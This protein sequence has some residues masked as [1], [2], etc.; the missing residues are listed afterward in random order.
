MTEE[1]AST[2]DNP[3]RQQILNGAR[4]MFLE[5]G[6]EAASMQDVA[7]AAGVSKGTLYVYFDSKEAM[8]EAL[9]LRE[10]S[11][12]QDTVR[13]IA[14]GS[15]DIRDELMAIA[16]QMLAALLQPEVLA[17]MRMMIG[18]GEKFPDLARGIYEAGPMRSVHT[19]ADYL[20]RRARQG[21]VDIHDC[22][23]AAAEF[24][25]LIVSGLQRRALLM[26]PPLSPQMLDA[27]V[28]QRVDR[29]LT[30]RLATGS[31]AG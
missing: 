1:I 4:R 29:F 15:G 24:L 20:C 2:E 12:L 22:D 18:A 9:V 16:R 19:L 23:A 27:F 17:A 7:R 28:A 30:G 3:K 6:F 5:H 14:S 21:D 31:R 8:F 26:M 25:D 11:R 13:R 10:C